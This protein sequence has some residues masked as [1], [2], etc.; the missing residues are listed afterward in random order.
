MS[1]VATEWGRR[2]GRQVGPVAA[3]GAVALLRRTMRLTRFGQEQADKLHAEGQPVIYAFWHSRLL[4][5]PLAYRGRGAKVLVSRHADGE[6]ISRAIE[7]LGFPT[8]RGSSTRGGAMAV[9]A[10]LRALKEGW[11]LGITP[12]GPR[13]PREQVQPGVVWT[14]ALSE[15]PILPVGFG[16]SHGRAFASWDRFVLPY[17][18]A[19]GVFVYGD[20]LYVGRGDEAHLEATRRLLEERLQAVTHAAERAAGWRG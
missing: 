8:I 20:P 18:G 16:T 9:R 4:L 14:A 19:R 17:P 10:M 7:G 2:L 5:M 6:L 3:R 11:D 15:A 13:G 1:G 12:D